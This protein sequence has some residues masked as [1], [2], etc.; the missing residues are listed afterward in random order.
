L[1]KAGLPVS[2]G[3]KFPLNTSSSGS[4]RSSPAFVT[5]ITYVHLLDN[6]RVRTDRAA[7]G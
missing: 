1:L 5:H 3:R 2:L 7:C 4:Q 6:P